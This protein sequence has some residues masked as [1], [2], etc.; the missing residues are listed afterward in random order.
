MKAVLIVLLV[1]GV[2]TAVTSAIPVLNPLGA[3][4]G[5]CTGFGMFTAWM[6]GRSSESNEVRR[7]IPRHK[8]A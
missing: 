8:A 3:L 7:E 5:L 1:G 6:V 2:L 4:L